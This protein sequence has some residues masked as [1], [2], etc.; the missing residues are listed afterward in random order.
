MRG[1]AMR[2]AIRGAICGADIRGADI[3]GA[4]I[5]GAAMRGAGAAG[6]AAGAAAGRPPPPCG[7]CWALAVAEIPATSIAAS[8]S[9]LFC[10]VIL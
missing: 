3:L 6:R 9:V 2:G 5:C 8:S 10:R 4:D 1:C 7:G